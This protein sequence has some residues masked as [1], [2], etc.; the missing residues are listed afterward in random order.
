MNQTFK[1]DNQVSNSSV[2]IESSESEVS[3]R[4]KGRIVSR[5]LS[6]A[7]RLWLGTQLEAVENLKVNIEGGDRQILTGKIPHVSVAADRVVYRGLHLTEVEL[8]ATGLRINI[9]QIIKGKPLQILESFPIF[10]KVK[11]LESDFN[12]SLSSP[13]LGNAIMDFLT[14]LL[15][16]Y[17]IEELKQPMS[18]SDGKVELSTS[19]LNL[20]AN[21]VPTSYE[22]IPITVNTD[23]KLASSCEL[24]LEKLD[25]QVLQEPKCSYSNNIKI[26]LGSDVELQEL[27]LESGELI[28][29]G[30]LIVNP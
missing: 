24:L 7:L 14:P 9:G 3:T 2:A 19:K 4:K 12:D 22:K 18:L 10:G 20:F 30:R 21:V 5:V 17:L 28:C 29:Q 13:L 16:S 6:P 1:I 25:I 11:L 26:D 27:T 8:Y 23:L 15:S